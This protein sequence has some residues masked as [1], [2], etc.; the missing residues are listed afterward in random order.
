MIQTLRIEDLQRMC[1]P[2][3]TRGRV[4]ASVGRIC[5]DS[6]LLGVG[7]VFI[8]VKGPQVDGHRFIDDAIRKGASVIIA[9]QELHSDAVYSMVVTDTRPLV[10]VLALA[11]RGNPEGGITLIG[12]TGTNGKTTV[13]TLVYQVLSSLGYTCGLIGTVEK[14]IGNTVVDSK[15]TT[16][17]AL[18]LADDL[19]AMADS[20]CSH[21]VMEVS[22]HAL[23][24]QR[25]AGLSFAVAGFTN[26][27]QD[28]LD[29]HHT[30]EAYA[31]SKS[32]L[33]ARLDTTAVAVMNGDDAWMQSV[34][35]QSKAQ[36]WNLS[37][38]RGS[39]NHIMELSAKGLMLDMEGTII[40]SPLTGRFNAYNVAMAWL[41]CVAAGCSPANAATAL[42]T[43]T[44][45]A[46]RM[47]RVSV[48]ENKPNV[49]VDYAHTPDALENV[50]KTAGAIKG[51]A[52]LSV[53]FGCGGNR[54]TT[55]RPQM[56]AI[57]ERLADQVI[58][59]SDNPRFEDPEAI[60]DDIFAGFKVPEQVR[61]ESDRPKA[62]RTA[63]NSSAS[64]DIVLIAGKGHET[65]QEI[66]GVRYPMDDRQIAREALESWH[67]PNTAEVV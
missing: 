39:G 67:S 11:E 42:G 8:A 60:I 63:I 14:R 23:D 17:G 5:V 1:N 56:A 32:L 65:Y 48:A 37:F 66:K 21:V 9:E 26:L 25:T 46:G 22:S 13:S 43:A 35:G 30:M 61:R 3:S 31:T 18:E 7:D 52:Q 29:Y 50:L 2:L 41:M 54:D 12:V 34:F 20:G 57:A 64:N 4:P 15:L 51:E 45:A 59:C 16:P 33:F 28:H 36:C 27:S 40:S 47:E 6:R 19:L 49:F 58:V 10:G 53:V 44:G 62:I 38:D 24:Q 55:K